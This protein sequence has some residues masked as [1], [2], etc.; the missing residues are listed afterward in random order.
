MMPISVDDL[1]QTGMDNY[2]GFGADGPSI[3]ENIV[4][5]LST[6]KAYTVEEVAEKV[7]HEVKQVSSALGR[8]SRKGRVG[9]KYME[10]VAYFYKLAAE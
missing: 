3:T 6:K 4:N 9:R 2:K 10:N 5:V 8:L 7:G 1:E